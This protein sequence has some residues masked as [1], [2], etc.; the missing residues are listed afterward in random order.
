M[1]ILNK[2]T[3]KSLSKN[4]KRTIV[5]IIGV[6]LSTALICAVAGMCMSFQKTLVETA[7]QADGNFHIRFEDV[8]TDQLKYIENNK[9]VKSYFYTT[10]LGYS[11]LNNSYNEYKPYLYVMAFT[12]KALENSGLELEEGRMPENDSELVISNHIMSNGRVDLKVGETLK[13]NIGK[14][15]GIGGTNLEQHNPY[16]LDE[17]TSMASE[18]IVDTYEKEYKIVGIISRPSYSQEPMSGPGYTVITKINEDQI[19][20]CNNANIS[21]LLNKP[22]DRN[23]QQEFEESITETIKTNTNVDIN[24]EYNSELLRFEGN[25]GDMTLRA[26]YSIVVV[27][28]AIIVVSS[29]FVI[30][31]SFSISVSEKTKQYGMM[32]SVGAT[33][34]QIRKSVLVEALFIGAI[35]VPL[36]I[37]LGIIAVLILI[38]ILNILMVDMINFKFVYDLPPIVIVVTVAMSAIT[39]FLS[40]LIPAI[41]ASRITPIEAI[42]ESK[43]LKIKPRKIRTSKITKKVF[44]IGGVIA[45]KNLKRSKKKYRTTVI[46]LVVSISIFIGL[47]S[48]IQYGNKMTGYYYT[49]Y[50]FNIQLDSIVDSSTQDSKQA[51]LEMYNEIIKDFNLTD[52]SY[53]YRGYAGINLKKY[54]TKDNLEKVN[55]DKIKKYEDGK[56]VFKDEDTEVE[57][58]IVKFNKDYFSRYLKELGLKDDKNAAI[59]SN[60]F[61][62][63]IDDGSSK[64][65]KK[66]DLYNIKEGDTITLNSQNLGEKEIT[67]TKIIDDIRPMGYS[68]QQSTG[69]IFVSEENDIIDNDLCYL[70]QMYVNEENPNEIESE[71][72]DKKKEDTRY[73]NLS[74]TNLETLIENE[75]RIILIMSI[76]L[77]G[78]ITVITLIGVTNI[79]NTITTNMILRSKEFAMLKSIGMT[80]KEFNRMIRLESIL[81]GLKSLLIGI[82]IGIALSYAMYHAFSLNVEFGFEIPWLPIL[83]SFVFV[84]IIV[85][86]TMKYS[87]NKINKQNIVETIRNDNI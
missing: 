24:I 50:G 63:T 73:N 53:S 35:G 61:Y 16:Q 34:K 47:S 41:R 59:L 58:D 36:G 30:R 56:Y 87:L 12:D 77:Y 78:F 1:N 60:D 68:M 86:L 32:A 8:P 43:D 79:F 13:L 14:R 80:T 20:K 28:I 37:F 72:L 49:D 31:N 74:I 18:T 69:Y 26:L 76:F 52:Y 6:A 5:T 10:T 27:I 67:I 54:A 45:S 42:R 81:Y 2:F 66:I 83:I 64:H 46:S 40:A 15:Q 39:I 17:E 55:L 84:F 48:F 9:N 21:V 29:V 3:I 62:I 19:S 85:G 11:V 44:G 82:P 57:I 25:M 4:K 71:L 38:W 23:A 22:S 7:K 51:K 70:S 33:S 65:T 75:K